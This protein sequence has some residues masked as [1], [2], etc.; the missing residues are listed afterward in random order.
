MLAESRAESEKVSQ[1]FTDQVSQ[2]DFDEAQLQ[3]ELERLTLED[4]VS[5]SEHQQKS[6]AQ[7]LDKRLEEF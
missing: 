3:E 6:D 1:F 7:A 2:S 5:Q 4:Q